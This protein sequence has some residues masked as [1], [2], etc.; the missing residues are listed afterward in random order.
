MAEWVSLIW[1][2]AAIIVL[3]PTTR[4]FGEHVRGLVLLLTGNAGAAVYVYFF[5]LLPGTAA[6]ELSHLLVAAI[7]GVKTG[8]VSLGP[9]PRENGVVQFGA[10]EYY[11]ADPVR[12]SL[13]GLAPL[14]VGSVLVLLIAH[15]RLGLDP[16]AVLQP[17]S[18][19][20][21]LLAMVR[22]QD[23]W[24]WVYL[25]VAIANA[26][27]P[28]ASDRRAWRRFLVYL[29]CA[30][31]AFLILGSLL[32]ARIPP[33]VTAWLAQRATDLAFAFSLTVVLDLAIGGILCGLEALLGRLLNRRI[34]YS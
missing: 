14:L 8:K 9:K 3:V 32:Q 25:L 5:L 30:L 23:V 6:H 1:F 26:M 29:L 24:L 22:A 34:Q 17:A 18:L 33:G 21:R 4:W 20:A 11:R 19:P 10:V 15:A 27:L 7:L 31:A 16:Q 28:S 2:L 13:V 12:E